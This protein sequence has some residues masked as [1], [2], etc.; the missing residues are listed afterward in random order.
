MCTDSRAIN[1][2]TIRY[3]FPLPRMDD[4]MD[5]LSGANYFSK[6]DLKSGY[7]QI[8][9]RE[10]DEWKTTF[11][12]NEGL[13]EWLVMPFGLTNAPSTFMR[14]M[15]EVLKEF[16]GKF[17]VV[18][19]DD[20]LIFS[21]TREEHLGHLV[22]VMRRLQQEKLLI[23]LKK[24][25]FKQTELI[26]LGFVISANELRMDPEKVEVIRK[27]P[28]PRNIFEVRSF[29]GLA[30]FY[31]KFI[32]NFSEISAAMMDTVRKRHKVFKWTAEAEKSFNLLKRKII[33]QPV[34]VLPDFRKT[35]QVRCDASGYAVGGVLS[36]EDRPVA[37]YSEKLDDAKLKYSTY[38]KEFY[39]IVQALKKWR[40]Y[41]IPKEFVLYSDNHA[42]QFVS[43]QEKLNQKHA[44]W[45]EY[46]Q[47]FTFVIN[48]I[49]GTANKVADALRR[50][51][52]LL[53]EFRVKTLGFENLRDM[54]AGD[55]DFGEAYEAAENPVL[56]DRSPWIDYLVQDRLLFKGNQLC[57]PDFSMR[58]NLV[59]E[60]H[61]GGLAG[62]FGHD[63]T[64][65][66]LGE[67]YFWPGMRADV[68]S[69]VDRCRICRHAKGRK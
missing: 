25:S 20:I 53:Q 67:S 21:K 40:H 41:L 64:Y 6:I 56:R 27:W 11:K 7:H 60:K 68:K 50:K 24:C 49:S 4:L 38:D 44:K 3:R 46:M 59:K 18:Y 23:N 30:S 62:H 32:R 45:V 37:Y 29:H 19:L 26:Y 42:L 16:I 35:F 22:T 47:N 65:A 31:R 63:K 66:K 12:T 17:V 39:A 33:E 52:L 8:R 36:Q 61:S 14:L 54:Y 28:S 48:H 43:Q 58:E 15:N 10:G 5:C 9:M 34:L 1:K 57:I 51:C 69:F 55:A 13:Y 2:I